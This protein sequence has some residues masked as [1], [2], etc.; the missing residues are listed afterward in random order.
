MAIYAENIEFNL[1]SM[2]G[3]SRIEE[4]LSAH[5]TELDQYRIFSQMRGESEESLEPENLETALLEVLS[6]E[7]EP[8]P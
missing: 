5:L 4:K 1:I 8:S 3:A 7:Q 2:Q 6:E